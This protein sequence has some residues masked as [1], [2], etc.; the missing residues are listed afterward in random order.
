MSE[1]TRRVLELVA[2][3]KVTAADA[4]ELLDTLRNESTNPQ[5]PS[6]VGDSAP[7]KPRHLRIAVHKVAKDGRPS[8]D[9]TIKVPLAI[10]RSGLRLGAVIPGFAREQ[11]HAKLREQGVDIDL[12][13][14]DPATIESLL[15][16][17]GE[18]NIDVNGGEQQVRI[19]CE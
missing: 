14:I 19:T 17:M 10:L 8:K 16:E 2:Q 15:K 11:M 12:A 5:S 18:V 3:G 4:E 7:D 13:K 6:G 9:V 1:H